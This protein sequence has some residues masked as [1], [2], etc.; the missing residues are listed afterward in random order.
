[1]NKCDTL[2]LGKI[3]TLDTDVSIVEAIACKDGVIVYA[4]DKQVARQLCC[5]NAII[6]DYSNNYIYPGFFD[7]HTHGSVAGQRLKFQCDLK[8]GNSMKDYVAILKK[9]IEQN[10]GRKNYQGSGWSNKGEFNAS[11]LDELNVDV[12]IIL[13]SVDGHSIWVNSVCLKE[14]GIDAIKAKELGTDIVHVDDNGNP[15]GWLSESIAMSIMS[16]YAPTKQDIKEGLLAWQDFAFASGMTAVVDASGDA[17]ADSLDAYKELVD[18]GKWKLRTYAYNIYKKYLFTPD[19]YVKKIKKD[20]SIYNSEYFKIIGGKMFIDG[21]VEAHTAFL[22]DSYADQKDYYGVFNCKGNEESFKKL[23]K[24][25]NAEKIP[26]HF[27]TIGDAA[28]KYA[29]DCIE[30]SEINNND[31]TIKNCLAHLEIIK[32][33]DIER[34][35]KLCAIAIVAPLWVPVTD[36]LNQQ[37]IKYIG[38]DRVRKAYPIK[39]FENAGATICFHTDYP[40]TSIVGYPNTFYDACKRKDKIKGDKSIRNT[41]EGIDQIRSLLAITVNGAYMVNE[42]NRLGRLIPGMIANCVV[43]DNDLLD[44]NIENVPN[45]QLLA[46]IIDGRIVYEKK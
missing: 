20:I 43:Y 39:S 33:E 36:Y 8:E 17:F 30:Y 46:T 10:P 19:E 11:M 9:Y 37:E 14:C 31:F 2:I 38:E 7:S 16:N 4:G 35:A 15:T 41:D 29:L 26:M 23:V 34:L 18:E 24:K 32:P 44:K 27:H 6:L 40:V 12:P 22:I 1:M 45:C 42:Q 28:A 3:L 21:V 13:S 25:L 5:D